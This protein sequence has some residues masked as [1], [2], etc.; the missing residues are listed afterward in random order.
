MTVPIAIPALLASSGL[1]AGALV[2][3]ML[4]AF[5]AAA[6]RGLTGFGMAIILVPLLC[7]VMRPDDAVILAILLQFMIGPIG[8]VKILREAHF[9]S[10]IPIMATAILATPFGLWLLANTPPDIARVSVAA[11]AIG[12]F[13]LVIMPRNRAATPSMPTSLV[14]GALAGLLTGFAAMPGPPVVLFYIR[15]SFTPSVARASMMLIFFATAIT[16]T[17]VAALSGLVS[18]PTVVIAF[19]MLLPMIAGNWIGGLAFGR[20]SAPLWRGAVALLLGGAGVS[21]LYR[22]VS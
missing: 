8:I 20:I 18:T 17:T 3:V 14:T 21:A 12:A 6:I 2:A 9:S 1:S 19:V 5:G 10:A 22:L 4:M 7:I 13:L 16:A 11:I 15:D